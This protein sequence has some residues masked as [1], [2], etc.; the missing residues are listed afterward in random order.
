MAGSISVSRGEK[1]PVAVKVVP[2][3][4]DYS[5]FTINQEGT[6]VEILN[7]AGISITINDNIII[8]ADNKTV[9]FSWNTLEYNVG[10]YTITFWVS[11]TYKGHNFLIRSNSI[12]KSIKKSSLLE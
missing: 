11:V 4:D 8:D 7:S 5:D 12:S 2:S 10:S 9:I 1:C 3:S 6:Y